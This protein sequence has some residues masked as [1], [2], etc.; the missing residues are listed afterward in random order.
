MKDQNLM[1]LETML[2]T[3]TDEEVREAWAMIAKEGERRRG[4]KT[5]K[6]KSELHAGD[7]VSW[8]HGKKTGSVV[9][10]KYKKAIVKEVGMKHNWDIPFSLLTKVSQ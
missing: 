6:M 4:E 3:W 9:R 5:K 2:Y 1:I 10:V 8:D 7:T